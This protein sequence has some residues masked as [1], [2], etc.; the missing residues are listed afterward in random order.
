MD[1]MPIANKLEVEGLGAQ[2]TSLFINFMPMECKQGILLRSPLSGTPV[3]FEMPGYYK[4]RFQV[5]VRGHD[6]AAAME[7]ME[8]VM[9]TLCLFEQDL[10]DTFVKHMRPATLPVT[11]P[12]SVGNFYEINCHFDVCYNGP[13]YVY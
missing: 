7:L 11:F 8:N 9:R 3:D 13:S 6:Y 1:M 5:I 10:D 4:T 2:G 12:V